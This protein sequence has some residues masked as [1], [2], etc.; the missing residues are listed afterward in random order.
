MEYILK[1]EKLTKIYGGIKAVNEVSMSVR[2]G[3]IYGFIGKN[4]AGKTT[5]MKMISG[6]AA[7]TAGSMELFGK[8]DLEQAQFLRLLCGQCF[9]G[10][11]A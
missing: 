6:L 4:G 5:F 3:D 11:S 9:P 10:Y 2:K 8:S 7:P 1:T